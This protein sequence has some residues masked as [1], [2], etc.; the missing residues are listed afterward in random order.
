MEEE[1]YLCGKKASETP[2]GRLTRDHIPPKNLFPPPLPEDLITVPCCYECNNAA[3][4]DDEYLRFLSGLY[5]TSA[6]GK[7]IWKEKVVGS[8]LRTGRLS[9]LV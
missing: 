1:C 7:Q 8:T 4:K 5:N 3:H 6:M 9:K 2:D